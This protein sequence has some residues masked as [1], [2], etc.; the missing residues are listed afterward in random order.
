M[1]GFNPHAWATG[2]SAQAGG[3]R[4]WVGLGQDGN[5]SGA[6]SESSSSGCFPSMSQS[7][8]STEREEMMGLRIGALNG[9]LSSDSKFTCIGTEICIVAEKL[10]ST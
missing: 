10:T 7:H 4:T 8:V 9:D 6:G 3:R 5:A 1:F 2:W